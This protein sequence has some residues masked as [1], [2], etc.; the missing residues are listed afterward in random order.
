MPTAASGSAPSRSAASSPAADAHVTANE[1]APL[2][3]AAFAAL[4]APLGPFEAAPFLAAAISGGSDSMAL[5]LLAHRWA[6]CRGGRL[7]AL[8]VDHGLRPDSGAEAIRVGETLAAMGIAQRILPWT[9]EKPASGIQQAARNARYRLLE[10]ACA[11]TGIL[12]LLVAHQ[13]DDQAETVLLRHQRGSGAAGLAGMSAIRERRAV[14]VLRPLLAVGRERLRATL[15]QAGIAWVD[16]PSNDNPAF[17]RTLARRSL[18]AAPSCDAGRSRDAGI[19]RRD[20]ERQFARILARA[21]RLRPEGYALID[22]ALFGQA[23]QTDRR[24]L[25][26]AVAG[27]VGGGTWPPRA[28]RVERFERAMRAD[29]FRQHT[30]GG[31]L[32]RAVRGGF[33]VCREWAAAERIPPSPGTTVDWDGRFSVRLPDVVAE[34]LMLGPLGPG[35]RRVTG[36]EVPDAVAA[37]LPALR[38]GTR[39]VAVA[40]TPVNPGAVGESVDP[41]A[42]PRFPSVFRPRRPLLEPGFALV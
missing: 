15:C 8:T 17:A 10:Q 28:E 27:C 11:E 29:G 40:N 33:L 25:L 6:A 31:C 42:I 36:L 37:A 30:L 4:M 34:G 35:M 22:G 21:V 18:A 41:P 9:G 39:I 26:S 1:A 5:A 2:D 13:A 16:D 23:S 19:E 32:V 12:H 14:R 20:A 38:D 24:R 3:D 7:L